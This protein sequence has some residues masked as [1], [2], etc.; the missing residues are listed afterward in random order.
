MPTIEELDRMDDLSGIALYS[1]EVR[2]LPYYSREEMDSAIRQARLGNAE[3]HTA[4][5]NR[6]LPWLLAKATSVYT[7]YEPRHS[8]VMDLLG[9]AHVDMVEALPLALAADRPITYL[10]SVGA[11]A[12][13]RYCHYS[14]PLVRPPR[15]R[16][17]RPLYT[18]AE[19]VSLESERWPVIASIAGPEVVLTNPERDE[20]QLREQDQIV[21]NALN[22]LS[23]RYRETL[24]EYY[25]LYGR[26]VKRAGDIAAERGM[27]KKA[28]EHVIRRA[29]DKVAEKLGAWVT[30]TMIE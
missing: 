24:T 9:A 10:M 11:L 19:V 4:L 25:G 8:D 27:H 17:D 6:C 18:E 29:K 28:V 1:A 3:A 26:P 7:Q 16:E 21:Y 12:M 13:K 2:R 30:A 22:E 14:D 15:Y 23:P 20:W 5:L